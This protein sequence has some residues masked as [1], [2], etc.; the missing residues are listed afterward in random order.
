[1]YPGFDG[2]V[3]QF[4]RFILREQAAAVHAHVQHAARCSASTLNCWPVWWATGR[5]HALEGRKPDARRKAQEGSRN[6]AQDMSVLDGALGSL[7]FES[8]GSGRVL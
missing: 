2:P 8:E 6:V 7:D 3:R 5:I 4:A 1:M